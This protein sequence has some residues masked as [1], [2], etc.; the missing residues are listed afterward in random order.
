MI[1][2][3]APEDRIFR[4]TDKVTE[5]VTDKV[6]EQGDFRIIPSDTWK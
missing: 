2:F 6:I 4:V 5:K 1:K 3:T